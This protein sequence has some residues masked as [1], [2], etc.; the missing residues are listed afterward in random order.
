MPIT[1][2]EIIKKFFT[3]SAKDF[4]HIKLG[5]GDDAAVMSI[6]KKHELVTTIDTLVEGVHFLKENPAFDIGHKSL[7]VSLSDIAAMGASPISALLSL[8]LPEVNEKWLGEFSKGFFS[9]ANQYKVP[10]IGGNISRGPLTISTVVNGIVPTRKAILR[11]GAK[12]GDLIYVTGTLG[13]AGLAL[14]MSQPPL[15]LRKKLNRPDPR[16]EVGLIL[17]NIATAAIDIS[18]GLVADLKKVLTASRVGAT[19]LSDK[20][21]TS[22]ALQSLCSKEKARH[23]SLTA[24]DDYELCFTIPSAKNQQFLRKLEERFRQKKSNAL[25]CR[26]TCIGKINKKLGFEIID[27]SG[28]TFLYEKEGYEHFK[29]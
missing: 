9:L 17:R 7:A 28:N 20:I 1:E 6:P 19:I 3:R 26:I 24:G 29:K 23:L 4:P 12:A 5:V 15:K 21:P 11:C 16:I 22:N 10:L 27:D 25:K 2:F 13:D 18:D 8:T 14:Q